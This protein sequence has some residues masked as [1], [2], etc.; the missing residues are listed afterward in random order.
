[1][2]E[3]QIKSSEEI[4]RKKIKKVKGQNQ[5]EK[6]YQNRKHINAH[7]TDDERYQLIKLI[8]ESIEL[9]REKGLKKSEIYQYYLKN[10]YKIWERVKEL[11]E[12]V[13]KQDNLNYF[14]VE[15]SLF[16]FLQELK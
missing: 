13:Q 3:K 14:L 1:M 12:K 4:E 9:M 6:K 10:T 8:V 16:L 5:K 7:L 11:L 15:Q 2:N